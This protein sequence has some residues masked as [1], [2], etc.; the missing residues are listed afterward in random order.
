MTI[1]GAALV[2]GVIGW[3]IR[4][5]RSPRLHG[6][7]LNR[8]G[9][10]GAYVPLA[11]P[12]ARLVEA[13]RSLPALGLRGVNVTVPHKEAVLAALDQIDS[14]AARLG[15]VNTVVVGVDGLLEGFNTD[16]FGFMANLVAA[17][18]DWRADAAPAVVIGAGGAARAVVA[19][20]ADAGCPEIR[21]TNR[22]I[23]RAERL[24]A[25]LGGSVRVVSWDRRHALL[26]QA[27]LVVNTTTQGMTGQSALDLELDRLDPVAV[28]TD[29]VYTPLLTPLLAAA[30]ARG[31]R[32]VDG[33]GML[34]HQARPGFAAWFGI[35]PEVDAGLRAAVLG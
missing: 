15:A 10:D 5:S 12:P 22:T 20:L 7:W 1:T 26:D 11:V 33:L 9:I 27:G 30:R 32:V 21:L 3:P 23:E 24:A 29:L 13:V 34:L 25:D 8:Y 6:F 31:N 17:E 4:H 28:V 2:A 35:E 16:G 18:P 14:G 19:A